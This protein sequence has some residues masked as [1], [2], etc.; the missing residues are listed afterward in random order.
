MRAAPYRPLTS[1]PPPLPQVKR[2]VTENLKFETSIA[3]IAPAVQLDAH[4][5]TGIAGTDFILYVVAD[6]ASSC[7]A[8][9]IAWAKFL[10]LDYTPGASLYRPIAGITNV[11]QPG[12]DGL[13]SAA[14]LQGTVDTM[15]HEIIHALARAAADSTPLP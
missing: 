14:T 10:D 2:P 6:S 1:L 11:C 4:K 13:A 5:T 3:N 15:T 12:V 9:T 8:G 7:G